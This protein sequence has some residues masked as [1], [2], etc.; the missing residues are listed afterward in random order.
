[1]AD[2]PAVSD[3]PTNVVVVATDGERLGQ[4]KAALRTILIQ[5]R[6]T[7]DADEAA[8]LIASLSP[9]VLV[10]DR[11]LPR[12][13]LFRLYGLVREDAS[14]AP[15]QIVFVGQEG[16]TG[17]DDHY[18]P[19][20]PSPSAVAERVAQLLSVA[21][22]APVPA[23]V[24]EAAVGHESVAPHPAPVAPPDGP[25]VP[26]SQSVR[27]AAEVDPGAAEVGASDRAT[28]EAALPASAATA[29]SDG[30]TLG[31]GAGA[32]AADVETSKRSGR[33]LKVILIRVGLALLILGA[34][35]I[36]FSRMRFDLS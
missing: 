11:G 16:E 22:S 7:L 34:L 14:E 5:T 6:A 25:I 33:R 28:S 18:L 19:G 17:P 23:P 15:V 30:A 35:L 2:R 4:Y 8:A 13:V 36:F 29:P 1:M 21:G 20:E 31:A 12:L 27:P 26:T 32:V 10:L 24:D 3:A 9:D